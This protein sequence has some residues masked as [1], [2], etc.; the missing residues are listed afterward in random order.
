MAKTKAWPWFECTVCFRLPR[1]ISE[2]EIQRIN[3]IL[4]HGWKFDKVRSR[5]YSVKGG[6]KTKFSIE[7]Y[8]NGVPNPV[9]GAAVAFQI[10]RVCSKLPS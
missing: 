2:E 8:L 9:D 3:A 4:P 1:D 5:Q 10:K 7:F 6:Y